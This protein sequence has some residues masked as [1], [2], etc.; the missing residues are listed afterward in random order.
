MRFL[1]IGD[2]CDLGALYLRLLAE[3]HEVKV[4]VS[5]PLCHGTLAGMIER[6]D[7]WRRELDWVRAAGDEG[8]IVFENVEA[9][10]GEIQDQLRRDGFNVIGGGGLGDRLV[11]ER[12]P[13]PAALCRDR[14]SPLPTNTL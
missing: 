6:T 5:M 14:T 10:R 4:Y 3:G 1:G 7:D 8:I 9:Q 12:R 11:K 2:S 13:S